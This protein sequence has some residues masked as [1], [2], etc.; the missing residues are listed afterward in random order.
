MNKKFAHTS[1]L[2]AA[3]IALFAACIHWV[4][5]FVG[6]DWY[7]FLTA[8]RWVGESARNGTAE[9]PVGAMV[10]GFLMFSCALYAFSGAGLIH[11]LPLTKTA[12]VIITS[13]CL[14]RG[15]LLLPFF[16]RVPER[17]SSFDIV[18]SLVWFIA[19]PGFLFGSYGN[20]T[21][22]KLP[23]RRDGAGFSGRASR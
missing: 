6:P 14:L 16:I 7:D 3:G 12:L 11:R 9:A 17:L 18:A 2:I 23:A 4:A 20:W 19:G 10:I 1:F 15:L 5:P 8:P 22:L 21:Q 13:I